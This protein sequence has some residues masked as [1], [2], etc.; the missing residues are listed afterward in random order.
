MTELVVLGLKLLFLALLWL[1]VLF[2]VN[3][4]RTDL[5]GRRVPASAVLGTGARPPPPPRPPGPTLGTGA[6]PAPAPGPLA[7]PATAAAP[8]PGRRP[9]PTQLRITAGAQAGLTLPLGDRLLIGRTSDANLV[10]DDQY[11]SMRHAQ[12]VRTASGFVVEDLGSTNGTYLNNV[13]LTAPAP[14]TEADTLRIGRTT[15]TLDS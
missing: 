4:I 6:R 14:L 11:M 9:S 2:A 12:I 10:L 13:R 15:I 1:F 8:P 3:A 5:F 7:T